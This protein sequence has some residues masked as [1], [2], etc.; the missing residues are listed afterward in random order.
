VKGCKLGTGGLEQREA[1]TVHTSRPTRAGRREQRDKS[2]PAWAGRHSRR[3][4]RVAPWRVPR[5]WPGQM[6]AS[7]SA[8]TAD[9]KKTRRGPRGGREDARRA[10][11]RA[12]RAWGG[13]A[14]VPALAPGI[15]RRVPGRSWPQLNGYDERSDRSVA[16]LKG[17]AERLQARRGRARAENAS[18][19]PTR[20]PTRAS[21]REQAGRDQDGRDQADTSRPACTGGHSGR[22]RRLAS[23]RVPRGWPGQMGAS[24][25]ADSGQ[26]ETRRGPR[27]GTRGLTA[28]E[29]AR[30]T[31]LGGGRPPCRRWLQQLHAAYQE[32]PDRGSRVMMNAATDPL[33]P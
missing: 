13:K 3:E 9:K 15:A 19:A 6:G 12:T 17:I 11:K 32:D 29:K 22:E 21:P 1:S 4:R 2:R 14:S 8:R 5:G 10:R 23:C 18:T 27:G 16:A 30:H 28:C 31:G 20:R 7:G 33:Q 24:G 25:G 26:K